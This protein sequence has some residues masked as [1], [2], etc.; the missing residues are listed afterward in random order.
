MNYI[1]YLIPI[2]FL[3]FSLILWYKFGRDDKIIETVEFY[4]PKGFNSLEVGFLY[5]GEAQNRDV[6]SLL[7]YLANQGYIKIVETEEKSLFAK[8]KGFKITILKE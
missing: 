7:M 3:I 5:K 8:L 6:T 2:L 4:P 1:I